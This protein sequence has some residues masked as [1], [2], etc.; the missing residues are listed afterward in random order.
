MSLH[1][2]VSSRHHS[3]EKHSTLSLAYAN[4]FTGKDVVIPKYTMPIQSI[5]SKAAYHL[6]KDELNLDGNP[7]TNLASFV[8]TYVEDEVIQLMKENLNKNEADQEEYPMT[9]ALHHRCINML[10]HLFNTSAIEAEGTTIGTSTIG[11]SEAILLGGLAMK[12]KWRKFR[13][14]QLGIPVEKF[15][16]RPNVIFPATVH[17]SILKFCRYFDVD[18]IIIPI[19][20]G[21][22]KLNIEQAVARIN[23]QTIGIFALLGSTITGEFDD[24]ESLDAA[25][26]KVNKERKLFIP[27]HIDGAS[28]G[29]V[30]PFAWPELKWDFRLKHVC[31]INVSGHKYGLVTPGIGWIVWKNAN[32]LPAELIFHVNYLG[33]DEA[34]FS[35]NFSKCA[36]PLIAQ[37][38]NFVRLGFAGYE[39]IIRRCLQTADYLAQQLV[40][41]GFFQLISKHDQ[42]SLP[43][44]VAKLNPELKL[45]FTATQLSHELRSKNWIVPAFTLPNNLS[46]ISVIRMVARESFT[47]DL[48]DLLVHDIRY[49]LKYLLQCSGQEE[50]IA[51]LERN[52]R[53]GAELVQKMKWRKLNTSAENIKSKERYDAALMKDLDKELQRTEDEKQQKS[54]IEKINEEQNMGQ[55]EELVG[56]EAGGQSGGLA[57]KLGQRLHELH[58]NKFPNKRFGFHIKKPNLNNTQNVPATIC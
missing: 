11:S 29:L 45:K 39:A 1:S 52:E 40:A 36:A 4:R 33:S 27:I 54:P 34:T 2:Q 3:S 10:A 31:S 20:E 44:V 15:T 23:E 49:A 8:T 5:P 9:Q 13:A 26:Q 14:A 38:Y 19:E 50:L 7:T 47:V 58:A 57:A 42:P 24:L 56:R 17:V 35:L 25:L 32:D 21:Q 53:R 28:G 51:N 6:V 55:A 12:F 22:T 46:A 16:E 41:T 37:Y 18:P 30:A 43:I 48:A